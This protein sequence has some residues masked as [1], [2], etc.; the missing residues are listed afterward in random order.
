MLTKDFKFEIKAASEQTINGEPVGIVSGFASTYGNVDR[1]GD[2]VVKG[3]FTKSLERHRAEDGKINMLFQ[4][5]DHIGHFPIS[6]VRDEKEGLFLEDGIVALNVPEGRAAMS[7]LRTGSIDRMSIG[8]NVVNQ[9]LKDGSRMLT[10]LELWEASIV[11]EPMN[12]L[13]AITS[14]KAA[15]PYK[16]FPLADR[17][18]EWDSSSAIERVREFTGSVD[19]PS[20]RYLNGF[21]WY[22]RDRSDDFGAYKLPFVDVVDGELKAVPRGIF[23]AAA[24]VSGARG[25]VDIP[26]SDRGSVISHINR[27]YEKTNLDSPLKHYVVG[28]ERKEFLH[29]GVAAIRNVSTRKEFERILRGSGCFSREAANH[30]AH[31]FNVQSQSEHQKKDLGDPDQQKHISQLIESLKGMQN[32]I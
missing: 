12:P 11:S 32:I 3:A 7:L 31:K 28:E 21:F 24:A 15:T 5:R 29:M 19:E 23:A 2:I 25:G 27:Y 14:V 18:M 9:E 8:F 20:S 22:D 16:D 6:K 13:A 30:L 10:E 4:H 1:G 17:D 26:N